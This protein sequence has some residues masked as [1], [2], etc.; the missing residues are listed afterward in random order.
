MSV[1]LFDVLYLQNQM[2]TS[3]P[4][5]E[6]KRLLLH[7]FGGLETVGIE[8]IPFAESVSSLENEIR[9]SLEHGCEGLVL[10]KR[11]SVY[12]CGQRTSFVI[13]N[14][15]YRGLGEVES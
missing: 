4:L 10:K 9:Q 13:L 12:S 2:I 1:K 11:D 3:L 7:N 14:Q 6:R 15:S 5:S 8:V